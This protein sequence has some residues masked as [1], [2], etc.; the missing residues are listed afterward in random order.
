MAEVF[1]RQSLLQ[2]VEGD[3]ELLVEMVTIFPM[4]T[5][6]CSPCSNRS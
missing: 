2:R 5:P 4:T 1:N 6:P 3:E